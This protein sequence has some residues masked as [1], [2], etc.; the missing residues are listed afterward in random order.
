MVYEPSRLTN[1]LVQIIY[2]IFPLFLIDLRSILGIFVTQTANNF[3][4]SLYKLIFQIEYK[5]VLHNSNIDVHLLKPLSLIVS[6]LL[7]VA[8]CL[9]PVSTDKQS[10]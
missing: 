5:I 2:D 1:Q 4:E 3:A 7:I 6:G 10:S 8:F 9:V